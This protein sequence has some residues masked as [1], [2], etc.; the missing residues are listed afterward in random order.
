MNVILILS[1]YNFCLLV[2][3][4][5]F[6]S[7]NPYMLKATLDV[8]TLFSYFILEITRPAIP[9]DYFLEF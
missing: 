4:V 9:Q 1:P 6:I 2:I 8:S 7:C 5:S 3:H